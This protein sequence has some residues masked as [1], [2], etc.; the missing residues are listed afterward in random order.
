MAEEKKTKK[1]RLTRA[2]ILNKQHADAGSV[3][4]VPNA[5][6]ARLVGSG[7]A[8]HVDPQ[9]AATAVNRMESPSNR[10]PETKQVSPAPAEVHKAKSAK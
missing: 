7:S 10:D 8:E 5:L 9:D 2:L 4:E 3:H 1:L 6:A